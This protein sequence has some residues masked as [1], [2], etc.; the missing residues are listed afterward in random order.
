M[1]HL[2]IE[3]IDLFQDF[4]KSYKNL[5]KLTNPP[6][7]ITITVKTVAEHYA[8]H[9]DSKPPLQNTMT[10]S[11][12]NMSSEDPAINTSRDLVHS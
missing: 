5:C 4:W 10:A 8:E 3:I 6:W 12:T 2:D 1:G 9:H 11:P 7:K